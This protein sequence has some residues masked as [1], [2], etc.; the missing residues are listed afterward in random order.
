MSRESKNLKPKAKK[1]RVKKI[2]QHSHTQG[3]NEL[4]G[5]LK[6]FADAW[7]TKLAEMADRLDKLTVQ[8]SSEVGSIWTA[9]QSLAKSAIAHDTSILAQDKINREVFGQLA[10]IDKLL[11]ATTTEEQRAKLLVPEEL[12]A[13]AQKWY[14]DIVASAFQ[15]VA[16]DRA[17][18]QAAEAEARQKQAE[19]EAAK[20]AAA[21]A[22]TAEQQDKK[23]AQ[24]V[25]T[26][27]RQAETPTLTAKD[28]G[29]GQTAY[30]PGAEFFGAEG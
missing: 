13:D 18:K 16:A 2:I 10:Q 20:Q 26:A 22:A 30:P 19:E 4:L 24:T 29:E 17:A 25:E 8:I 15:Q 12:R 23:E 7:A 27:L 14:H 28:G 21:A 5:K 6:E 9:V 1:Q 11:N 3:T